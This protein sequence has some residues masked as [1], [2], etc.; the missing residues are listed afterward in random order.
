MRSQGFNVI[1]TGNTPGSVQEWISRGHSFDIWENIDGT[2]TKP[3][4]YRDWLD[5]K[6]Y[7]DMSAKRYK[8]FYE[9]AT[10]EPGIYITTIAWKGKD[11]GA[12]ATI[13]QRFADGTL[14]YIEPQHFTGSMKRSIDELC[15]DGKTKIP[16]WSKRGIMRVDN[17]LLKRICKDGQKEYEIWSIFG[18]K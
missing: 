12:H 1:A 16:T 6:G 11:A 3:T 17:K 14:S 7:K 4:L 9:E 8:Q 2:A 10:T 18:I 5:A 15:N 13:V